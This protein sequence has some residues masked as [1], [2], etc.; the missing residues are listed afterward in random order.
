MSF[1]KHLQ[2]ITELPKDLRYTIRI[3]YQED[4]SYG[5]ISFSQTFLPLQQEIARA[6][7]E[8][9][10]NGDSC[11]NTTFSAIR[12]QP[13]P[14]PPHLDLNLIQVLGISVAFV[15][16]LSFMQITINTV[17]YIAVE[18]EKQLKETMKIM[19]LDSWLHW[20][21]WFLRTMFYMIIG[22]SIMVGFFKV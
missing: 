5:G 17:R 1:Y 3:P 14:D 21:G 11:G 10:C 18:K 22:I 16:L 9:K 20:T 12:M 4:Y 13:Q 8:I 19:G 15:I 7:T 2:D 6:F